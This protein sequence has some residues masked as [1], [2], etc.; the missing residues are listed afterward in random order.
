MTKKDGTDGF[1]QRVDLAVDWD[2]RVALAD[3]R[4]GDVLIRGVAVWK[5]KSGKLHV[6]WPS[7][8]FRE[9][10]GGYREAVE[11]PPDLRSEIEADVIAAY[12]KARDAART[13][14]KAKNSQRKA[15]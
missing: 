14:G 1:V 10:Q 6:Q 3:V 12:R 7:Y 4:I 13:Q 15:A 5:A 9:G 2:R 8:K 11:L